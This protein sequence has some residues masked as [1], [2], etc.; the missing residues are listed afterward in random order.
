MTSGHD[1]RP[2]FHSATAQPISSSAVSYFA[3]NEPQLKS[4]YDSLAVGNIPKAMEIAKSAGMNAEQ[5][6]L[7]VRDSRAL[8]SAVLAIGQEMRW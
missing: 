1:D 2:L 5:A 6:S 4:L 3:K 8:A 7:L